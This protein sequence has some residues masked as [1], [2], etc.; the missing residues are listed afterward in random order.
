MT[1]ILV[2]D[3]HQMVREGLRLLIEPESDME[4]VGE[5]PDGQSALKMTDELHPDVVVMDIGLPVM[6]G[7][8]ATRKLREA[9][10]EVAVIGLSAHADKYF[11]ES[12]KKLGACGYIVKD[13][14]F[15]LL[16]DAIRSCSL[17]D[18]SFP[19]AP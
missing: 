18:T 15:E 12:M 9:H 17:G 1:R 13:K 6:D 2:V 10:P 5:A 7:I 8:E 11:I 16:L 3:D 14:A 4:L 19:D